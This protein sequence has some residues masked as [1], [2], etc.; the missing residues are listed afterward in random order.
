MSGS[1]GFRPKCVDC[2]RMVTR[3]SSDP[4]QGSSDR[5]HRTGDPRC[6]PMGKISLPEESPMSLGQMADAFAKVV[7]K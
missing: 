7:S 4:V 5:R 3:S 2:G 6:T 1:R